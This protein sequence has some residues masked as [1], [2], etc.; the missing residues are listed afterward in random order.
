MTNV[1]RRAWL[2]NGLLGVGAGIAPT[3]FDALSTA[4]V[5]AHTLPATSN[6]RTLVVLQMAGGNDGLHAV[7]PYT[8]PL[9]QHYRPTLGLGAKDVMDLNG[10]LGLNAKL[11]ALM[12]LWNNGQMGVVLGVGYPSPNLSHFQSM[13][14]WQTL[15]MTGSQ[16]SA[17]YG[18]L[19][20]Y[21]ASVGASVTQPFAGM[22]N[23]VQLATALMA[24]N[25]SVPTI[26]NEKAFSIAT[27]QN[28]QA[29]NVRTQALLQMYQTFGQEQTSNPYASMLSTVS[30]TSY[31]ATQDLGKAVAAYKPAVT[32]PTSTLATN[33]QLVAAAII[34][35][36]GVRIGYVS[37]GGFDTHA[38]EL[39][40]HDILYPE[41]AE[42][43]A[44]FFN[45]LKAHGVDTNV[46]MMTWSE[47]GRRVQE[48]G[49]GGTDHGT[50]APLFVFGPG[51]KG[52]LYGQQPAL[53]N[54]DKSGNLIF[55]TDFRSVYST[56]LGNWL[57]TDAASILGGT[58]PTLDFMR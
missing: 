12:P 51:V 36:L 7:A 5:L 34:E 11:S 40:T 14:I 23:G 1:S 57:Q 53:S 19:G 37:L 48:N 18:W 47:F 49:S 30:Q 6:G 55:S 8:D 10:S 50:A 9:L 44:A 31:S 29:S 54:L 2:K 41:V 21:L 58:Y 28:G 43:V 20:K 35:N 24:P 25:I 32:Y 42:A 26:S 27:A 4:P 16:G 17:Q 39:R 56:I 52:G 3:I 15:D 13:Y 45:D 33:L 22:D 46:V 38:N